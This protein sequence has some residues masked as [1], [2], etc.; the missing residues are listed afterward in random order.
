[1]KQKDNNLFDQG[2]KSKVFAHTVKQD[3]IN[4]GFKQQQLNKPDYATF[5]GVD[6]QEILH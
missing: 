6:T 1:M 3:N 5:N 4:N 2:Y